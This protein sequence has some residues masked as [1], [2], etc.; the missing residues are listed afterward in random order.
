MVLSM[1]PY[2]S[3]HGTVAKENKYAD[4]EDEDDVDDDG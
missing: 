2:S 1:I 4:D 3:M